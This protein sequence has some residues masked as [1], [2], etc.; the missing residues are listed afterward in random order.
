M[1]LGID[2]GTEAVKAALFDEN[3]NCLAIGSRS[4]PTF[5]PQ[6]GYA[7]Q[8]PDDWWE[9][10]VGAVR[11]CITKSGI[12]PTKIMGICADATTCTLLPINANGEPLRYALLWMDVRA[13]E[14]ADHIYNTGHDALRY[15]LAGV[16]AEWMPPK[17]LWLK[18]HEATIYNESAYLIEYAD[19]I[20]YRLTGKL[21]LNLNTITQRWYYNQGWPL[22]F[23]EQAGLDDVADKLLPEILPPGTIVEGLSASA[24]QA[25]GLPAGIPVIVGGGDAFISLPG[26]GVVRPGELGVV[27]GSSNV[28]A[29][30]SD[31]ELHVPGIFGS[32]PDAIIPGLHLVEGGQVS[33]GSILNW[34]KTNFVG[35]LTGSIYQHL[36][37][38]AAKIPPGS[39]GLLVLD[40][41]QGNR[42]PHTDSKARG[43]IVGLTLQATRGHIFR[44]LM[45]GI[46]YGLRDILNTFEQHNY[47]IER[48]IACGGATRSP[49]FMQIYAD[50]LGKQ[51]Y[52]T[53][54]AEAS[55]LGSAIFAAVGVGAFPDV[56]TASQS[57][58]H[59]KD[60]FTPHA[61]AHETYQVYFDQYQTL[62]HRLKDT[63]H[64]LVDGAKL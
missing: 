40:Y 23:Y 6:P 2:G 10:I 17:A 28:L 29:G 24:S 32:F 51:L 60:Q 8:N 61:N 44:A 25:L 58:V 35:H 15:S 56:A 47:Q 63:M 43:T 62:Y 1:F 52:T 42:T 57:M 30:L 36:D 26:I 22:D 49:T 54:Q 45:E 38:E 4:Y 41:F 13:T 37:A 50:V 64:T 27:M 9:A 33:T 46:A 21:T 55:A 18:E 53:Q 7:E 3:G 16:S 5:F 19:W 59:I 11:D 34:F 31:V 20:A 48:I 39:D 12:P 14:Q